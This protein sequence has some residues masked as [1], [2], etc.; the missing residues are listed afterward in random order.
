[1]KRF[2]AILLVLCMLTGLVA[3]VGDIRSYETASNTDAPTETE[4]IETQPGEITDNVSEITDSGA[5]ITDNTEPETAGDTESENTDESESETVTEVE[6]TK[7]A[8]SVAGA[9]AKEFL[10]ALKAAGIEIG[11]SA[12]TGIIYVGKHSSELSGSAKEHVASRVN[13]YSDFAIISDDKNIAIYGGSDYATEQAIAFFIEKY[14]NDD[15][16]LT[17]PENMEYIMCP[18]LT[19]IKIGDKGASDLSVVYL[20]DSCEGVANEL[21]KSLSIITGYDIPVYVSQDEGAIVL[22]V[23]NILSERNFSYKYTASAADNMLTLQA[24]TRASLSYAVQDFVSKMTDDWKFENGYSDEFE[25][26]LKHADAADKELFKYCGT[27]QATDKNN[28]NT[29]V[30]Y[31]NDSYVEINFTGNA[32]TLEFSSPTTFKYKIDDGDYSSEYSVEDKMHIFAEGDGPH[33]IRIYCPT[34]WRHLYFAGVSVHESTTLSRTPDKQHYIHF[35]GDSV[36]DDSTSYS[37]RVGDVLGWD[38]AVT[39]YSGIALETGYGYWKN[40]NG[41]TW[42]DGTEEGSMADLIYKNFGIDNIGMEDAF[43]KLGAPNKTMTSENEWL[44]YANNY[45]TEKFNYNFDVGYTPDIVVIGLGTN[46]QIS[47]YANDKTRFSQSYV[48]FVDKIFEKYGEGIDIW[49]TDRFAKGNEALDKCVSYTVDILKGKYGDSIHF[50]GREQVNSWELTFRDSVH[51]DNAGY[52][53]ATEEI[54]KVL[55]DYYIK[56][57]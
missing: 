43:F 10:Y 39:A 51:P 52:T 34:R 33:T 31:W 45:Y 56:E 2:F 48:K 11:K 15:G 12:E 13:N 42:P 22:S 6:L 9:N 25:F 14:I 21:A 17:V 55:K 26:S 23:K 36:C 3:C 32:I 46:D 27:W 40:N 7:P 37:H 1:M 19:D 53:K 38:F 20:S 30:S 50:I 41:Y 8:F 44:D 54:S 35:I 5:E 47:N 49:I 24:M 16:E 29:M 57:N 28:P 18:E 4:S